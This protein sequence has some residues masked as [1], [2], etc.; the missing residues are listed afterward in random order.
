M[1]KSSNVLKNKKSQYLV[2]RLVSQCER[3]S[4]REG[5]KMNT[6]DV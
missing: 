3:Y 2:L 6:E 4:Q 1:Y 5:D